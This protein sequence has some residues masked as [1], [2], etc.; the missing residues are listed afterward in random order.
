MGAKKY[1]CY[2][3]CLVLFLTASVD[4]QTT[5]FTYQGKLT[6]IGN[7]ASPTEVINIAVAGDV[8]TNEGD[9]TI[10]IFQGRPGKPR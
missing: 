10:S 9:G 8:S 6:E 1:Q 4:A 7:T 3:A 2:A 5:A